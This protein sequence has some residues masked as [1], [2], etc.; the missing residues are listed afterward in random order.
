ML[1]YVCQILTFIKYLHFVN[2][3]LKC[4]LHHKSMYKIYS[5]FVCIV[6][7]KSIYHNCS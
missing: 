1:K 2:T 7:L 3:I 5:H 6:L 4:P